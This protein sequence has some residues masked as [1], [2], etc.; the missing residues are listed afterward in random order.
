MLSS[1]AASVIQ[2]LDDTIRTKVEASV[3]RLEK[4][5]LDFKLITL[6]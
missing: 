3:Q 5:H 1:A 4:R 2:P 6:S